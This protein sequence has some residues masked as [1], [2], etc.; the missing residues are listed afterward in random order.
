MDCLRQ[1]RS[2]AVVTIMTS[3]GSTPRTSG[4]RMVVLEDRAIY[5][6]IGGGLVEA[7]LIDTAVGLIPENRS[8]ID[9][10]ALNRELKD[11]LDMVCGGEMTVLIETFGPPSDPAANQSSDPAALFEAVGDL[12]QKGK[13]GA[14]ISKIEGTSQSDFT[15]RK[16]LVLSDGSVAAGD[17]SLP[18]ILI[19]AVRNS[20][21]SGDAPTIWRDGLEAYIV[22]LFRP[23]DVIC[24]F[25]AGHVGFQVARMAHIVDLQTVVTDDREEFANRDRFPHAREVRVVKHFEEAFD[26]LSIDGRAYIVILTRGHLH[27][28]TV[29]EEALKTDAAYIGMIGSRTKKEQIYASLMKKGFSRAALDAVY[30]PIGIDI[31]SETPSEIAVSII[32]QIIKVRG[33]G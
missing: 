1:G 20:R 14:I 7:N 11:G 28:E 25:G 32:A 16:A 31:N 29:L 26:T 19:D 12:A 5:G 15:T 22:E 13:S 4:S 10:F 2:F 23:P 3:S 18:E 8:R 24:I 27:D 30:A 33:S 21:F 6:T 17:L 9:T